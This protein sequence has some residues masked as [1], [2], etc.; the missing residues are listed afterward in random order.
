MQAIEPN[1]TSLLWFAAFATIAIVAF[2]IVAGMFPLRSRPDPAASNVA[3][4]LIAG[5]ALLLLALLAGTGFY[6][7]TELRWSTLIVVT[8][9][10]VLFAPALFQ[11]CPPSLRDG[12]QGLVILVGVQLLALAALAKLAGPAFANLS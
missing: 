2:L 1:W 10:V 12:R 6:G 8:G 5:N 7:Y 4:L 3:T 11:I 9:L